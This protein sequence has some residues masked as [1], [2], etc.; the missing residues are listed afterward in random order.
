MDK[1][2]HQRKLC[3]R[4]V[5]AYSGILNSRKVPINLSVRWCERKLREEYSKHNLCKQ[6][7]RQSVQLCMHTESTMEWHALISSCENLK[8]M[9][10][11]PPPKN[12]ILDSIQVQRTSACALRGCSGSLTGANK[13][14]ECALPSQP[15]ATVSASVRA[16]TLLRRGPT[17]VG[18]DLRQ[19]RR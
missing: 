7:E 5:R 9:H 11:R 17:A 10:A 8:P 14:Q 3:E 12:V 2:N 13:P 19:G 18:C 15:L 16:S 1:P 4:R 6:G